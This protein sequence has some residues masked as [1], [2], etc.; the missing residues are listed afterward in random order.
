MPAGNAGIIGVNISTSVKGFVTLLPRDLHK[1]YVTT[2]ATA[3]PAGTSYEIKSGPADPQTHHADL[4]TTTC[5]CHNFTKS[6]ARHPHR[7]LMRLCDHLRQALLKYQ[8]G[9]IDDGL[10]EVLGDFHFGSIDWIKAARINGEF[11]Y[12][13]AS[14]NREWTT[15]YARQAPGKE[16]GSEAPNSYHRFGY[17]AL[18]QRWSSDYE[19]ADAVTIELL[20]AK[21]KLQNA[22]VLP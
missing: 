12:F 10:A 19:P 3:L 1:K 7:S 17:S 20:I 16:M 15:V 21:I 8:R 13:A 22:G 11:V 2:A 18:E 6:R 14:K 4:A 5:T 9:A